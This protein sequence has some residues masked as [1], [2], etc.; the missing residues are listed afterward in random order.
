MASQSHCDALQVACR[1]CHGCKRRP[2][3]CAMHTH[4]GVPA[5][6]PL[7]ATIKEKA[8]KGGK[9]G[10]KEGKK[11]GGKEGE[12][13]KGGM[14]DGGKQDGKGGKSGGAAEG[15]APAKKKRKDLTVSSG[16]PLGRARVV[17]SSGDTWETKSEEG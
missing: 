7:Q 14:Q 11:K 15:A 10:K 13:K 5:C 12:A 17:E 3:N 2:N 9:K 6:Q 16:C 8:R 4:Q 1:V